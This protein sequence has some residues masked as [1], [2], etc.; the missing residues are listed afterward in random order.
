MT[1]TGITGDSQEAAVAHHYSAL[2][3]E[4]P[5]PEVAIRHQRLVCASKAGHAAKTIIKETAS[6]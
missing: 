6:R 4:S 3:W 5:M 2:Q 1:F